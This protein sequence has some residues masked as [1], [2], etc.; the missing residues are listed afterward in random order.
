MV[1]LRVAVCLVMVEFSFGSD[2]CP[3]LVFDDWILLLFYSVLILFLLI[4]NGDAVLGLIL[5]II[6]CLSCMLP[7]DAM[8]SWV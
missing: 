8:L 7:P 4:V 1:F 3:V 2:C 6:G 5:R